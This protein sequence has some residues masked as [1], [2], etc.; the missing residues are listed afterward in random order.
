MTTDI[1]D[2]AA[3]YIG[4]LL[5]TASGRP[6]LKEY[7]GVKMKDGTLTSNYEIS[8]AVDEFCYDMAQAIRRILA[9]D[10]QDEIEEEVHDG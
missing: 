3:D 6:L 2:L 10:I 4:R 1:P 8:D 7:R 5:L 9:L